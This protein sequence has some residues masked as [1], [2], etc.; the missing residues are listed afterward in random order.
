MEIVQITPSLIRNAIDTR[1]VHRL[2]FWDSLIVVSAEATAC[3]T[4]LTEDLNPGY[5]AQLN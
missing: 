4:L 2:S 1:V 5:G 3:D